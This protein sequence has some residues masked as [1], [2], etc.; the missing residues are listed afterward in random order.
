MSPLSQPEQTAGVLQVTR[1]CPCCLWCSG[2]PTV[3]K[4]VW[5]LLKATGYYSEIFLSLYWICYSTVSVLCLVFGLQGM[6]DLSSLTK[7]QTLNPWTGRWSLNHWTTR[8]VHKTQILIKYFY[9]N[10][11]G[12]FF[13]LFMGFHRTGKGQFSDSFQSQRKAMPMNAQTTSQLHLF[14]MP[15]KRCSK[16]SKLGFNSTWTSRC[17]SWI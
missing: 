5:T 16:F 1:Y 3:I 8:E 13:I 17:S 14:R 15:A 4:M 7:D 11:H 9:N 6:W 12:V 10:V 2:I